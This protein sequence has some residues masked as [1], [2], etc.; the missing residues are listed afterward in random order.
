MKSLVVGA[1]VGAVVSAVLVGVLVGGATTAVADESDAR[2]ASAY[3]I[4]ASGLVPI[5][6]VPSV[7]ATDGEPVNK[8]LSRT[9]LGTGV[10]TVSAQEGRAEAAV[11]NLNLAG[12]VRA[13]LIRT[14]CADGSGGLEIADGAVLGLPLP[15]NP[16]GNDSVAV[17]SL[18]KVELNHQVVHDDGTLTVEGLTLTV[19]P[20]AP[21]PTRLLT[22]P[23]RAALPGLGALGLHVPAAATTVADVLAAVPTGGQTFVIGSATCGALPHQAPVEEQ[24]QQEEHHVGAPP[25]APKPRIVTAHLPVTG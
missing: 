7:V 19:L 2:P 12:L 17:S 1:S 25:A 21:A 14:W 8:S 20:G 11:A 22:A 18:V 4:G 16:L 5:E 6:H 24:E 15:R 3:G 10:F 23:E 13:D 9:D